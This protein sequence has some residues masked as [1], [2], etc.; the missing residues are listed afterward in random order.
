MRISSPSS[1]TITRRI[2]RLNVIYARRSIFFINH[3]FLLRSDNRC[4][5]ELADLNV[6]DL[7]NEDLQPCKAWVC[8]FDNG[9][10]NSTGKKQYMGVMRHKDV[11]V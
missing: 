9:K 8:I 3:Y 5:L 7:P 11:E 10:T 2:S 1:E 6:I 4:K